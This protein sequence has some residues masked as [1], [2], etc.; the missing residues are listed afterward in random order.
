MNIGPFPP[1]ITTRTVSSAS[2]RRNASFNST[3]MPAVLRVAGIGPVQHD[4]GDHPVV[5]RL[6]GD[7]PVVGVGHAG[8]PWAR[9]RHVRLLDPE[10]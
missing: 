2:A 8:S 4:P 1:K 7:E 9:R 10:S 5:E 6:V 3:N